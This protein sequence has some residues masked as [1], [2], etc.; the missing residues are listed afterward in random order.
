MARRFQMTKDFDT[1]ERNILETLRSS[2]DITKEC[3]KRELLKFK[4][5]HLTPK[6]TNTIPNFECCGDEPKKT[7]IRRILHPAHPEIY[8]RRALMF[9]EE[10]F[11]T[12][13]GCGEVVQICEKFE[14][15]NSLWATH[16]LGRALLAIKE[17]Q[18]SRSAF[19]FMV[20]NIYKINYSISYI[21]FLISFFKLTS[22]YSDILRSEAT[23]FFIKK[24]FSTI[25]EVYPF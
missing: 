5:A 1:M 2:D 11:S 22:V 24:Y 6:P 13:D 16:C 8:G 14:N 7:F 15:S 9:N 12:D 3:V 21:H 4:K 23:I 19:L 25:R 10:M 17:R 20:K 18:P